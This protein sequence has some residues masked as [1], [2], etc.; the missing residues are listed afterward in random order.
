MKDVREPASS[1]YTGFT[2]F[3]LPLLKCAY[4][5]AYCKLYAAFYSYMSTVHWS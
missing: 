2:E 3:L 5:Y 4:A 1:Y